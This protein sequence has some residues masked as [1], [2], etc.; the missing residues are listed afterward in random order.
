[1]EDKNDAELCLQRCSNGETSNFVE[2]EASTLNE[3]E[4]TIRSLRCLAQIETNEKR[5][6]N[7]KNSLKN[8]S[9]NGVQ[10]MNNMHADA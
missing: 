1:M 7:A 9:A 6:R 5:K 8:D 4:G 3:D 2:V 10:Q